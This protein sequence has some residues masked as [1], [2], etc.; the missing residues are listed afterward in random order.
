[1]KT[2]KNRSV[3]ILMLAA[4]IFMTACNSKENYPANRYFDYSGL[5]GCSPA[6]IGHMLG[7]DLK[8]VAN[9]SLNGMKY[10]TS[11]QDLKCFKHWEFDVT[12]T[13]DDLVLRHDFLFNFQF[14]STLTKAELPKDTVSLEVFVEAFKEISVIKPLMIDLKSVSRKSDFV[15]LKKAASDIRRAHNIDI[16]FI[17]D[18]ISAL[19]M[20]GVCEV[21]AG[22]F[23]VM[24]YMKG[25]RLCA[26]AK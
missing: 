6:N 11:M 21:M 9:N 3:L 25:G 22:E 24:L 19:R 13:S 5:D 8:G 12:P 7:G 15:K 18:Q 20:E 23:D 16:W 4:S 26:E 2:I 1:M 17:T 14:V 10:I